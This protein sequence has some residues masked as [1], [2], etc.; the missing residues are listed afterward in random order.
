MVD[1]RVSASERGPGALVSRLRRL[2]VA[3][4]IALVY[5][6]ARGVTTALLLLATQAA[7]PTSRFGADPTLGSFT[8]GWDAQWYWLIA[9]SGY[10][11]ELPVDEYGVVAENTW[12]FM[13]VY[14]WISNALGM[15]VGGYTV[16][17]PLVSLVAGYLACLA[18]HALLRRRLDAAATMWAVV[19]FASGP[20]A[21]LFQ[22]GYAETLF[23]LWLFLGLLAVERRRW[24][25]LYPLAPLMAFTRPG[26]LAFSLMLAL[27]GIWRW[28]RRTRDPLPARDVVHIVAVGL[29]TAGLGLAWPV[30]CGWVTGDPGA[31]L[32]TELA[33]RRAW[34]G[35]HGGFVP[36]DGF[37]RAAPMWFSHWGLPPWLGFVALGAVVAGLAALLLRSRHVRQV[38]VPL[39]LWSASYLLYLLAVF[40][41]QSSTFRLLVP[42]S[43]LWGAVAAPRSTVWRVGVLVAC[44]A[45]Q[46][47]WILNMF[48]LANA[49]TQVP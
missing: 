38:G 48:G 12:A 28:V 31:Y 13:P 6:A 26:V 10:P 30:I 27:Y 46:W 17:A 8:M 22:I 37:L 44:V 47:W 29:L 34:L 2:P 16:A 4:S 18:L 23:L 5:L 33:W 49:Y 45:L 20:L 15:G 41:P 19:F 7:T 14:P 32:Q 3:A 36:F 43:P 42:L 9:V 25:W 40:F 35:D 11:T 1:R 39:R 24:W 21:A